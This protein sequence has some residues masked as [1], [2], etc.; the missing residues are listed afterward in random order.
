MQPPGYLKDLRFYPQ[1]VGANI[2]KP[3]LDKMLIAIYVALDEQGE[4]AARGERG[5]WGRGGERGERED[6]WIEGVAEGG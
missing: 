1:N 2:C 3:L 6:V 4:T 5:G